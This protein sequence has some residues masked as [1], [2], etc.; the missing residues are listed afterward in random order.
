MITTTAMP[1]TSNSR[2]LPH[3]GISQ[4]DSMPRVVSSL[5]S[6]NASTPTGLHSLE[7]LP[8]PIPY[9]EGG[10]IIIHP[11]RTR[12][13]ESNQRQRMRLFQL[14]AVL[15]PQCVVSGS[16]SIH[17]FGHSDMTCHLFVMGRLMDL[18]MWNRWPLMSG[19]NMV[20]VSCAT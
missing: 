18:D 15:T 4:T 6:S 16:C 14:Q 2:I 7:N 9:T 11:L 5:V 8:T 1:G 13:T 10:T 3:G 17:H 19:S 12:A 20:M